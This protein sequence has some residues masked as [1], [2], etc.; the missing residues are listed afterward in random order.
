M[1]FKIPFQFKPAPHRARRGGGGG[2]NGRVQDRHWS[3]PKRTINYDL[4]E[5]LMDHSTN[6]LSSDLYQIRFKHSAKQWPSGRF[7]YHREK[8]VQSDGNIIEMTC[9]RTYPIVP[10]RKKMEKQIEKKIIDPPSPITPIDPIVQ[11]QKKKL[12]DKQTNFYANLFGCGKIP[13]VIFS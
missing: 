3:L 11:E 2:S 10:K 6:P 7:R 8:L 9:T 4:A 12:A 1:S 5:S 13:Q